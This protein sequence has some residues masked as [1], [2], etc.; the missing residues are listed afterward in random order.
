MT[1]Y[2][3]CIK[4]DGIYNLITIWYLYLLLSKDGEGLRLGRGEEDL[5]ESESEPLPLLL[6]ES[7]WSLF[8]WRR[9]LRWVAC[10][11]LVSSFF[12]LLCWRGGGEELVWF[13]FFELL[14]WQLGWLFIC[15]LWEVLL[16]WYWWRWLLLEKEEE[17]EEEEKVFL[18]VTVRV[19]IFI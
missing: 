8:W 11:F 13:I 16:L 2:I 9:F 15:L 1:K 12:V 6:L 7:S 4:I 19:D 3:H 18:T 10:N 17:E 5:Y 14:L